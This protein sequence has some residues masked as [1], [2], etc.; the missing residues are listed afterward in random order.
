MASR[1]NKTMRYAPPV[2]Q[3]TSS[4]KMALSM[5]PVDR[6][7]NRLGPRRVKGP[8]DRATRRAAIDAALRPGP[9][10]RAAPKP[11]Q[12]PVSDASGIGGRARSRAIDSQVDEMQ[13]GRRYR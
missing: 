6:N 7:G 13:T 11:Q 3:V 4:P 2:K 5:D 1:S 10:V 9:A 12:A 8:A